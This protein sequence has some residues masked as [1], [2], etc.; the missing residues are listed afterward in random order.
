MKRRDFVKSAGIGLAAGAI[1]SPAIAQSAPEV[2]WRLTSSFPKSLDT[3]YGAAETFAKAVSEATDNKFQVQVFAAGEIVPGLQASDA[4]TNGTVEEIERPESPQGWQGL[5]L[6]I[7]AGDAT[8]EAHLGPAAYVEEQ[9]FT[10]AVGDQ[11]EIVGAEAVCCGEDALLVREL[12]R[13]GTALRLRDEDGRP[14]W[15]GQGRGRR[16]AG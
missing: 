6:A 9:G 16:R 12:T 8:Y 14:L 5:H 1:A 7:A 11:V 15:A 4:V 13:D 10:F 3:I 2:K